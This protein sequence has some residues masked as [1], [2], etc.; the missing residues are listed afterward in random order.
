M[1]FQFALNSSDIDLWNKDFLDTHL[2]LL[3][4]ISPVKN[5]S[6]T[7]WTRIEGMTSGCL[8]DVFSVLIFHLPRR[9]KDILKT[10]YEMSSRRL[11]KISS[12]YLGK[13]VTLKMCWRGLQEMCWR[14][15]YQYMSWIRLQNILKTNKCLLG[16]QNRFFYEM[17]YS[18]VFA[19]F[20][21]RRSKLASGWWVECFP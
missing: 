20:C 11:C 15:L 21:E 9:L 17:F 8:E 1:H 7:S 19:R 2:D 3:D 4:E 5:F 6:E 16:K 12:K 13:T 14:C 18:S 10:S